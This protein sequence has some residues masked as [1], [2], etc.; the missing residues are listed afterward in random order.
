MFLIPLQSNLLVPF[1][2][3]SISEAVKP[4]ELQPVLDTV[5]GVPEKLQVG[6]V[7]SE[8]CEQRSI[9]AFLDVLFLQPSKNHSYIYNINVHIHILWYKLLYVHPQ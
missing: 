2:Q 6:G 9:L 1:P 7:H 8:A 5:A 3:A 4:D